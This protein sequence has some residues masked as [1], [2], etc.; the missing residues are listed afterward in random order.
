MKD[1]ACFV[2]PSEE[3]HFTEEAKRLQAEDGGDTFYFERLDS[4]YPVRVTLYDDGDSVVE[5]VPYCGY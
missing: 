5:W 1:S 3:I 4:R 2:G